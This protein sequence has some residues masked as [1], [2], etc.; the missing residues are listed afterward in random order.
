MAAPVTF[1]ELEKETQAQQDAYFTKAFA[2]YK[3]TVTAAWVKTD[4]ALAPYQGDSALAMYQALKTAFPG[5]T[6]LQRG[7]TVYQA[8]ILN[9]TGAAIVEGLSAAGTAL[10]DVATGIETAQYVPSWSTGLAQLLADLGSRSFWLRAGKVIVGIALVVIGI[11]QLTH[12]TNVAETVA[13]GAA[14]A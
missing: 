3:G 7:A 8:W 4:P 11:V 9:G 14:L 6:P 2:S 5:S 1:A 12:V 10:G 13:K